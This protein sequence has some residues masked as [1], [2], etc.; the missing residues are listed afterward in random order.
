V[1]ANTAEI[2]E[3]ELVLDGGFLIPQTNTFGHIFRFQSFSNFS[4]QIPNPTIYKE[5]DTSNFNLFNDYV[6]EIMPD[7]EN[8][9]VKRKKKSILLSTPSDP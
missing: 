1:E 6:S 8:Y 5:K 9:F 7:F 4:L 3:G 2:N